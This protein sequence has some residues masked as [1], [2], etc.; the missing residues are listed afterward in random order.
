MFEQASQLIRV[1]TGRAKNETGFQTSAAAVN[2]ADGL[3]VYFAMGYYLSRIDKTKGSCR[4]QKSRMVI[5]EWWMV[6][7]QPAFNH[8]PTTIHHSPV[9]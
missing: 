9:S 1:I 8:P 5:G 2:D 6:A 7:K 4:G 3:T